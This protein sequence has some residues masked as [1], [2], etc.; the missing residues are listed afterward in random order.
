[1]SEIFENE[2]IQ[3]IE[4]SKEVRQA[5]LDYSMSVIVQRALPDVRDGLKPV[6][7][8]ILYTM[9]ENGLYPNVAYRKCAD[10]V[11]SVLGR[12]H[13]HGDASVYDAMVRLAQDFSMR[14]MLV[15]GHGNFG[16]IDGDPAAAYRYTESR[17]SKIAMKMLTDI[18]KNT[19]D[20][21]GNYDDRL[22]EPTVLPA[23]FPNLLVN[24]STGIA[25]GM[26]TNIPP[27][28]LREVVEGMCAYIDNP[29]IT[30]DELMQYIKGPDFPTAGI[31]MGRTGIRQAYETGRGKIILRARTEIKED[32]KSGRYQIVVTELPYQV[33]KARLIENIAQ[34]VK[35]KRI[36]GISDIHDY[37]GREGMDIVID[38]KR[39]A[40]PEVVLN[41]LFSF[42]QMQ[43]S[44]GIINL[45]L[46]NNVPR[47]LTLKEMLSEYV[48]HQESVI[49]RRT[50]FDLNKA[51][52]RAHILKGLVI[53][54]DNIDEVIE[55]LK[56]SPS[57]QEG[58]VNLI[59]RFG[60]DDIQA[61]A[62]VKMR[63]GQLTGLERSKIED[64]LAELELKIAEYEAILADE[65]KVLQIIKDETGEIANKFS[66]ERRTE[67]SYYSGNVE[68]ED[69]IPVEECM[70]TLTRYGYI[71]RQSLESYQAQ[72]RGGH[73]IKGMTRRE[74]DITE[75]MFSISTHDYVMFFTNLGKC[76]RLK[77]YKIPEG[78]RI[79]RGINI[80]NLLPIEENEKVTAM[81]RVKDFAD[82]AKFLCMV[83]RNGVIKRTRLTEYNTR[84]K[85]G[86]IAV[87]L[88]EGDELAWVK[89]TD[90]NDDLLVAT[91]KG[92]S[93][94]FNENDARPI[95]RT[96]RGVR[97]IDLADGDEVI[98]MSVI[99]EGKTILTVSTTGYGRRS[100][101]EDYRLQNRAGK[102]LINYKT[103]EYG[104]V[105]SVDVVDENDDIILISEEGIIIRMAVNEI[106][107]FKRP[108]K[109][110]KVMNLGENDRVISLVRAEHEEEDEE[111]VFGE[112]EPQ[113]ENTEEKTEE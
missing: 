17:M 49:K 18:D 70:I 60:L 77:G 84:R 15:D 29:D 38:I 108:S 10:T 56:K 52:E 8:R 76:Y 98:G 31:I 53:A 51:R 35:D 87:V 69:L 107:T 73:G 99:E 102:G 74:E 105:A 19:V 97:A 36:E 46:V 113:E 45:A 103:G 79:S 33:N 92:M 100:V 47:I 14:H 72:H 34:L 78:S 44:Y 32:S 81:L 37:S 95:G 91:R 57:V 90:G 54:L 75:S 7:R 1:M 104:E 101:P 58:K 88:D 64:E 62:I 55:I 111:E 12:Y 94:R 25:V 9:Y 59:N 93:I 67:I 4:I 85:G 3:D 106:S 39:E 41:Q 86:L 50:I 22:Q 82:E 24:G 16:S 112:A 63:L 13:P 89:L 48:K 43:I 65:N 109:G 42:S 2:K 26:A 21:M 30:T 28:N 11:G 68:D 61:D 96:A 20:T 40:V 66:D 110:V 80:V 83:T 6:H 23:R 5:F 71:K 27:H